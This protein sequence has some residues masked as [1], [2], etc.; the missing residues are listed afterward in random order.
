MEIAPLSGAL[1]AEVCGVD[2]RRLDEEAFAEL[3]G[4]FLEHQFIAVRD[5]DLGPE[6]LISVASRFGDISDYPFARGMEG[7]PQ[8]TEIIKEP[9]QTSNFGGMWHSDTTYLPE[10][11]KCTVLYAVETPPKG[12]DTLFADMYTAFDGLSDGFRKTLRQLRGLST[13]N[14]M[15]P[16]CVGITCVRVPCRRARPNRGRC[17]PCT[18]WFADIRKQSGM[19][20]T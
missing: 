17:R 10:P 6:E 7:H 14:L 19:P 8:I 2:V 11:P 3:Y 12:G 15:R 4:V 5:Q 1:G 16:L 13:S 9:E 18:R 20:C